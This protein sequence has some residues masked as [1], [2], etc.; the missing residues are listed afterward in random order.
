MAIK[1]HVHWGVRHDARKESMDQRATWNWQYYFLLNI[2]MVQR[3]EYFNTLHYLIRRCVGTFI[4]YREIFFVCF[5]REVIFYLL[6]YKE[7]LMYLKLLSDT[8]RFE[9]QVGN[10][11]WSIGESLE[12]R[13]EF[14]RAVGNNACTKVCTGDE[15]WWHL[16]L[17][18]S[19]R[20]RNS[21]WDC[22][23]LGM[24]RNWVPRLWDAL[25]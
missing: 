17:E 24:L 1:V 18:Q 6:S 3:S 7:L 23:G 12:V 16:G 14:A 25:R 22:S 15:N 4:P 20:R 10:S 21:F 2:T 5:W 11:G 9:F 13:L 19:K 8:R